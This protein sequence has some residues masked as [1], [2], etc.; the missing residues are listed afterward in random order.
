MSSNNNNQKIKEEK[1]SCNNQSQDVN[2]DKEDKINN[3]E[4]DKYVNKEE[5][6]KD[7]NNIIDASN[8]WLS[9]TI[10]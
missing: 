10:M 8:K 9:C 4:I 6:I 2:V 5:T 7:K 1:N 3:Q